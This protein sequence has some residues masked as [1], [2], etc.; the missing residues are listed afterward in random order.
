M[1]RMLYITNDGDDRND[2][3]VMPVYSWKRALRLKGGD[4]SIDMQIEGAAIKRITKEIAKREAKW[5]R[6]KKAT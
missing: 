3:F 2:G 5:K 1:S 6:W 4:N